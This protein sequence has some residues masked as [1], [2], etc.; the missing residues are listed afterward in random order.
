MNDWNE[1]IANAIAYMEENLTEDLD[2]NEIAGKAYVSSFYFQKIFHVLSGFSAV[3]YTHLDVYKR[4][5]HGK[6]FF[7]HFRVI[8]V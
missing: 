6:Q 2:V 5:D 1:G 3:S 7:L 8:P 4:Q